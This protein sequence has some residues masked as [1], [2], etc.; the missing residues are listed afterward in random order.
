MKT[1]V[2]VL[3]TVA[4]P[5]VVISYKLW[6]TEADLE[7]DNF[8]NYGSIT[9]G[10]QSTAGVLG[11]IR[12][13]SENS[14]INITNCINNGEITGTGK[15]T[16][17]IVGFANGSKTTIKN[18]VNEGRINGKGFGTGGIFGNTSDNLTAT[19]I[20]IE[21]CTN[22]GDVSST[23]EATGGIFGYDGVNPSTKLSNTIRISDSVNNGDVTGTSNG[24]GGIAGAS[25]LN[26]SYTTFIIENS[27]NY[28]SINGVNYVAGIAGLIRVSKSESYVTNCFNFGDV[29]ATFND[30][31][32][33]CGGVVGTAR[34][35]VF[36][37]GCYYL[38]NLT[39][40]NISYQSVNVNEI[41]TPGFIG[42]NYESGCKNH[43]NNRLI[44][45]DKS[46]YKED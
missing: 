5:E 18:C 34:V 7:I 1:G 3:F 11:H 16:A 12:S 39:V 40:K 33:G 19:E 46:E 31:T 36:N 42:L 43:E 14:T 15:G 28:G 26:S 10:S 24:T 35:N 45:L 22:N 25:L 41:G 2:N 44:N 8:T 9:S 20:I 21:N 32:I 37:C 27:D 30:G 17:G 29:K 38:V 23:S 13:T 4:S 6:L